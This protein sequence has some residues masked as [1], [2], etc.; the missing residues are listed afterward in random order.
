M[1]FRAVKLKPDE[2]NFAIIKSCGMQSNILEKSIR[3]ASNKFPLSTNF[4]HFSITAKRQC[5]ALYPYI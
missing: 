3:R 1:R 5:C 4:F 2:F